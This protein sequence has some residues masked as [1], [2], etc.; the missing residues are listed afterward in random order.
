MIQLAVN[1]NVAVTRGSTIGNI[2]DR[3][4]LVDMKR[5]A[6]SFRIIEMMVVVGGCGPDGGQTSCAQ[7]GF[8]LRN[9]CSYVLKKRARGLIIKFIVVIEVIKHVGDESLVSKLFILG[10]RSDNA[11]ER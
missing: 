6:L 4:F 10:S 8:R 9:A 5:V 7:N 11:A 1:F 3:V 2:F